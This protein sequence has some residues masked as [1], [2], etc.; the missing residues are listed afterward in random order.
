MD[1]AVPSSTYKHPDKLG[2]GAAKRKKLKNPDDKFEAVMH[3]FKTGKLHSGSGGIVT[4]RQQALAIAGSES[5][6]YMKE[7]KSALELGT[8]I[9]SEH[10]ET[11]D[12]I[13]DYYNKHDE[14]PPEKEVYKHIAA[15]HLAEFKNYYQALM[16]MEKKLKSGKMEKARMTKYVKRESDGKGGYRYWYKEE[17]G[18]KGSILSGIMSF[19]GFK[20]T[21]QAQ[22]KIKQIY[23]TNKEKL[24]G[25]SIDVFSDYVNEYL[26]NKDKWDKKFQKKEII[27]KNKATGEIKRSPSGDKKTT[28]P[29][30][31]NKSYN[32]SLMKQVAG[33]VSGESKGKEGLKGA[34]GFKIALKT[35]N[36]I[37]YL[38]DLK[39]KFETGKLKG[40]TWMEELDT[41]DAIQILDDKIKSMSGEGK[42]EEKLI[43][44]LDEK[45]KQ[46]IYDII[47]HNVFKEAVPESIQKDGQRV[48]DAIG[49][50]KNIDVLK[51]ILKKYQ[52]DAGRDQN[53]NSGAG[54][55]KI[56]QARRGA[57]SV[58]NAAQ[59]AITKL[60]GEK[61]NDK[62][63]VMSLKEENKKKGVNS[64][65]LLTYTE[66]Q[67]Q[68]D[69]EFLSKLPLNEL[70]KRQSLIE[71]Q[72]KAAMKLIE[73]L[74][75]KPRGK[76][77]LNN[78][79][80]M[81]DHLQAAIDIKEFKDS[82]P[83]QW[84]KQIFDKYKKEKADKGFGT[85]KTKEQ[86]ETEKKDETFQKG[87]HLKDFY[88]T[89]SKNELTKILKIQKEL[90]QTQETKGRIKA[91]EE[92]LQNGMNN[93]DKK[94]K[95][96]LSED[97]LKIANEKRPLIDAIKEDF[98]YKGRA[99]SSLKEKLK[100]FK[101]NP[102][103]NILR[104]KAIEELI[105]EK[106]NSLQKAFS[107]LLTDLQKAKK[108]EIGEVRTYK[109]GTKR[110][111][112]A[113][114]TWKSVKSGKNSDK[115]SDKKDDKGV[116]KKKT[117]NKK[118]KNDTGDTKTKIKG[119]LKK[120]ADLLADALSGKN[121][122]QPAGE[123]VEKI[124]ENITP[125]GKKKDVR[126][127]ERDR[128]KK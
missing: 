100:I 30:K 106:Q 29:G 55:G 127:N 84:A 71:P 10:K 25:V 47:G 50:N 33:I 21:K 99:I 110:Q 51:E 45:T 119:I 2:A 81:E 32:L 53:A 63:S 16:A 76:R 80:I 103:H 87:Y 108:A 35:L 3:E 93:N 90:A 107:L 102:E 12:F 17:Q 98:D 109:D 1:K 123:T 75:T 92:L 88:S 66:Q 59:I 96:I 91:I 118:D 52:K 61:A 60:Q 95:T 97:Q 73:S 15:N 121:T 42:K 54:P 11:F 24:S 19:F 49:R 14:M 112:M 104:I 117:D 65:D 111:K 115:V 43:A 4:S 5:G 116:D 64:D 46:N 27:T 120:M 18:K 77:G 122:V 22:E 68:S 7:D 86:I 38:K 128:N 85:G 34:E 82:T 69:I 62:T 9:E 20:D 13:R 6:K 72:R 36:N 28:V 78:L 94:Y 57:V 114:G 37:S 79:S 74:D 58:Y 83:A 31:D 40:S 126:N 124:G 56:K 23:Q 101:E 44:D 48:L 89:K 67:H 41:K 113:D 125:K 8:K 26:S 105:N 70:R 39:N